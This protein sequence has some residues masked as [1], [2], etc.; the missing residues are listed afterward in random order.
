MKESRGK[1]IHVVIERY[2]SP[3]QEA[4]VLGLLRQLRAK[5]LMHP[6]YLVGVVWQDMITENRVLAVETWQSMDRWIEFQSDP[7]CNQIIGQIESLLSTTSRTSI[8]LDTGELH[9]DTLP[10]PKSPWTS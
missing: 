4:K 6:G 8:Y 9:P 2:I 10:L 3:T 5:A 1:D 7:Q